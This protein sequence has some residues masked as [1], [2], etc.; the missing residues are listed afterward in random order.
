MSDEQAVVLTVDF[1]APIVDNA[2]DYGSIAAANAMSDVYAMGGEVIL[3]LNVAAFPSDLPAESIADILRGGAEVLEA[4]ALIAG[5]HT[6]IDAEP[7]YGLSVFGLVHP[8]RILTKAGVVE[9]DA[10][11]L[12]ETAR[13]RPHHDRGKVR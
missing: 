12:D 10:V 4:G 13:D 6:V 8:D 11:F 3:A 5:G 2:Y 7:K 1:F 9:G